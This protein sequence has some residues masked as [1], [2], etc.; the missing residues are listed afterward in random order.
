MDD[1]NTVNRLLPYTSATNSSSVRISADQE[2]FFFAKGQ[3]DSD[4]GKP[5]EV[6]LYTLKTQEYN[7]L[8]VIF[9]EV[10]YFKPI[11][12]PEKSIENGYFLPKTISKNKFEVWLSNNRTTLNDFS[13]GTVDIEILSTP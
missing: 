11:L 6:E 13:D 2:Y 5:D 9:S 3:N 8:Y 1:G 4:F 10:D 12:N 7:S